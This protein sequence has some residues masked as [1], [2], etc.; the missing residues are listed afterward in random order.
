M[1]A[2]RIAGLAVAASIGA[3]VPS[4]HAQPLPDMSGW[5][6]TR[7]VAVGTPPQ[8]VCGQWTRTSARVGQIAPPPFM[9]QPAAKPKAAAAKGQTPRAAK[10][11]KKKRTRAR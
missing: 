4:A 3:A 9:M 10:K 6:C 1:I 11:V 5:S 8:Q 7:V 2:I